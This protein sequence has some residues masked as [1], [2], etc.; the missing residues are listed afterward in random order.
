LGNLAQDG[1]ADIW[2]N[3]KFQESRRLISQ[4]KRGKVMENSAL[5]CRDCLL[6]GVRPSF[7]ENPTDTQV[8]Q[9]ALKTAHEGIPD[10]QDVRLESAKPI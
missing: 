7:I 2:N 1:F 5:L 6:T 9:S 3:E 8:K 10:P 4:F